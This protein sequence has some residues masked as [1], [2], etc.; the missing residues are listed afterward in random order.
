M[1]QRRR[2]RRG[3]APPVFAVDTALSAI[4]AEETLDLS[5]PPVDD[6][7]AAAFPL[8]ERSKLAA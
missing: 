8:A 3:A 5:P 2:A 1:H 4:E 7:E 6:T